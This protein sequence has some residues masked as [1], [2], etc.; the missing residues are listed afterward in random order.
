VN[1]FFFEK[2]LSVL[3]YAAYAFVVFFALVMFFAMMSEHRAT[4]T[5]AFF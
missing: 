1:Y 2:T 5:C 4:A 3:E